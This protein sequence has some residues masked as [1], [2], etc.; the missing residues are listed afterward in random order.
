MICQECQ[1]NN[2]DDAQFC[3]NCG[4]EL[5]QQAVS[6]AARKCERCGTENPRDARFCANCGAE[7]HRHHPQPAHKHHHD[8]QKSQKKKER[9]VDTR[10]RWHPAFV[11]LVMIVGIVA[12]L[13]IP[14]ITGNSP[15]RTPQPAPLVE[16]RSSDPTVEARVTEIA[17]KFICSCGS[18]GEQPLDICRCNTAVQ[19]RQFI[20]SSLQAGNTLDQVTAAVNSNFGWMKPEFGAR[21]DSLARRAGQS[22]KLVPPK[23][24]SL[25]LLP[26]ISGR[27]SDQKIAAVADREGIFSRFQCP[28]G[29][30]GIDELKDCS[31]DHPRGA[32]EVKAFVD[33]KITENKYTIAQLIDQVDIQYGGRKF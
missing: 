27:S 25:A 9:R 17:S 31:C 15:G 33:R 13:S 14:Y 30:C 23:Q 11:V 8:Q 4:A 3:S 18:C 28:C 24:N 20:R 26:L 32:R 2:R 10:L 1:N 16:Q 6:H 22:S 12:L 21:Y 7:V 19:E 29:Q 5:R